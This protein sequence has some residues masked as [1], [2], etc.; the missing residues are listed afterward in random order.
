MNFVRTL[1]TRSQMKFPFYLSDVCAGAWET[2]RESRQENRGPSAW[3]VNEIYEKIRNMIEICENFSQS[4]PDIKD[5]GE[6]FDA[7]IR[8]CARLH[9]KQIAFMHS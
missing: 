9:L 6:L 4:L 3:S 5:A 8:Q 7:S 1:G 2:R